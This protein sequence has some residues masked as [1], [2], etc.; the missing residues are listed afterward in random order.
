MRIATDH[1]LGDR[2]GTAL[3]IVIAVYVVVVIANYLLSRQ[4]Y[5]AVNIAGEGFLRELRLRVFDRLQAQSMAFYDR[6]KAGVLVS[7]MTADIESMGELI[8][9]GLLQFVSAG[10][11]VVMTILVMLVISWQ[12]TLAVLVVVPVAYTYFD[13]FGAWVGRKLG[14]GRTAEPDAEAAPVYGD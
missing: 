1:G 12:L 4:Q 6:N 5:L 2:N 3:N 8:Q 13:D 11:L 7:R 10:L 9:W 14:R